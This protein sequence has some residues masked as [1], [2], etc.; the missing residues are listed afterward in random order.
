MYYNRNDD[1][2]WDPNDKQGIQIGN[3]KHKGQQYCFL[4]AIEG[5][6]LSIHEPPHA[7]DSTGLV[8]GSMSDFCPQNSK[9]HEGDYHKVLNGDNC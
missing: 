5:P 2:I 1:S 7:T 8:P 6:D 9:D 4:S 3:N